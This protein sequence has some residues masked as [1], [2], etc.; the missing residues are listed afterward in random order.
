[1]ASELNRAL[2]SAYWYSVKLAGEQCT[3]AQRNTLA[4]ELAKERFCSSPYLHN[5][6]LNRVKPSGN[7][8]AARNALLRRMV[9]NEGEERLGIES[10]P[11]EGGLYT[12]ILGTSGVHRKIDKEWR[13]RRPQARR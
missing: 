6:L 9:Q 13:F 4:S 1:M 10:Y 11:A 8:V 2:D 3:S 5:E 12:S 7:A